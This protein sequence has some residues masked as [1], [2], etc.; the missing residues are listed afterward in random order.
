MMRIRITTVY[1]ESFLLDKDGFVLEYSNGLRK[2]PA[3]GL[4]R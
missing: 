1:G 4:G 3:S 2:D